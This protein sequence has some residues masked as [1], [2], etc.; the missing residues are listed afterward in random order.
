M[1]QKVAFMQRRKKLAKWSKCLFPKAMR[2][3]IF[4]EKK[5]ESSCVEVVASH[6]LVHPVHTRP[7]KQDLT[8]ESRDSPPLPLVF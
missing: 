7:S 4:S 6:T 2:T 5:S 3:T 1:E 8:V